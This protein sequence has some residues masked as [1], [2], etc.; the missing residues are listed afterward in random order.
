MGGVVGGAAPA[1]AGAG[2][3]YGQQQDMYSGAGGM[4]AEQTAVMTAIHQFQ[5]EVGVRVESIVDQL[6][7]LG[8]AKI[9]QTIDFLSAEG[10][11]YSTIDDEHFRTTDA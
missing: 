3:A 8:E 6:P 11:I 7:N 2:S 5:T 4:N 10:H 9:R 1:V